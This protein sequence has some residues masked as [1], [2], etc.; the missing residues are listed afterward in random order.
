M[1]EWIENLHWSLAILF[2]WVGAMLRSNAIFALGW[3]SSTGSARF[4]KFQRVIDS[5]LYR[6]AQ[7]FINRWGALAVVLCF[8]TVGFQTAVL[9]ITGFSRMP[10]LRWIPAM[11]FGTFIWGLVYGTIGMAVLWAWLEQPLIA[12]SI[13][14]LAAVV[15][16]LL[17]LRTR[18]IRRTKSRG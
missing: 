5:P 3:A 1:N 16:L 18:R 12:L 17:R 7:E 13:V 4:A 15:I 2:F 8:L 6:R 10:L 14:T 9:F 11:L